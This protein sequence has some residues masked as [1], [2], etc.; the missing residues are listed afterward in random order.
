M[1]QQ[2]MQTYDQNLERLGENINKCDSNNYL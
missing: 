2:F 1:S